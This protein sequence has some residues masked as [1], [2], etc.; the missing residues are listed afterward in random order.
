MNVAT[1]HRTDP[2]QRDES[3]EQPWSRLV[4]QNLPLVKYVLGKIS[5]KLPPHVDRDDLLA[6]GSMGLIESAR[7][8][9]PSRNVPFH[10][11]SIPR[12]WGAMLDELRKHDRLSTDMREQ[13]RNLERSIQRLQERGRAHPGIEDIAE[14]M[15]SSTN[16]VRRLMAVAKSAHSTSGTQAALAEAADQALY[17]RVGTLPPRGPYEEAEF[18]DEK[19]AL[20]KAIETL[21]DREKKVIVLRYHEGLYLH[22]IGELLEVSE[23]RVCQIHTQALRRLRA[24]LKRAGLG[25]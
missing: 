9:D 25:V 10:S 12:I 3:G 8:F 1:K 4:Q 5:G 7:K 14:D 23:S 16:R 2:R 6:A 18:R 15:G 19:K 20:V 22:E 24:A 17:D 13:V 11:Y 21:P